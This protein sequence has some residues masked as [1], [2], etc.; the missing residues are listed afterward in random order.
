MEYFHQ[1]GWNT[2]FKP[3]FYNN[4]V[5]TYRLTYEDQKTYL[6]VTGTSELLREKLLRI[7]IKIIFL[8]TDLPKTK[9]RLKFIEPGLG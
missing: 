3:N 1:S 9:T 8:I 2:N 5:Y 4:E 6:M 7:V